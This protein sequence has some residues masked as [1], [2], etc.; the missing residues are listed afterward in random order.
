M[1]SETAIGAVDLTQIIG[2]ASIYGVNRLTSGQTPEWMK[3][4]LQGTNDTIQKY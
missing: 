3:R 1:V 2:I 4:D